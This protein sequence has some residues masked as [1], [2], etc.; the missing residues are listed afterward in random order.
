MNL[1]RIDSKKIELYP[2]NIVGFMVVKNESLRLPYFLDYYDNLGIDKFFVIDNGSIDD[3]VDILLSN[4]KVYVFS[5]TDKFQ[6]HWFWIEHLLKNYGLN[7]W[8]LVIDADELFIYP[9]SEVIKINNLCR[10]LDEEGS[11]AFHGMLL[12]MYANDCLKNVEYKRGQDPLKVAPWFDINTHH[13]I[14]SRYY[15][16]M[17]E[18]IFGITPC[19]TKYP[20]VRIEN[21]NFPSQGMHHTSIRPIS[22]VQGALLHFKYFHDF[23]DKVS[24]GVKNE[25]HWNNS[26]EYK[27]YLKILEHYPDINLWYSGS[28]KLLKFDQLLETGIMKTT[29]NFDKYALSFIKNI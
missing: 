19:I 15:G 16:G 20:L 7:K 6:E 24:D 8:C 28:G 4:K 27:A 3:T 2:E 10:F 1:K 26:L 12:D 25:Q 11:K 17:R 5:T 14:R 18:R 29:S 13:K 21:E 22:S 23:Y 9:H